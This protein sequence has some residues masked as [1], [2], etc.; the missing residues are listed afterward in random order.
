MKRF[1]T[2]TEFHQFRNI[3]GPGHPLISA[4]EVK[5][6][7]TGP[8]DGPT[9]WVYDFY[10]IGLKRVSSSKK[11]KLKYGQKEYDFDDGIMSFVAPSQVLS[12]TADSVDEIR[13][14]GWLLL[15]P[16]HFL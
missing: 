13:Q 1:K 12:L 14:S 8:I 4:F 6:E 16:P 3:P 9:S 15:I 10:C 7:K 2:I 11:V 5:T